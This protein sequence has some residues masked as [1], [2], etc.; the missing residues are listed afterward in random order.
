MRS[1]LGTSCPWPSCVGYKT[2]GC[3]NEAVCRIGWM[4]DN[5]GGLAACGDGKTGGS[6]SKDRPSIG[7]VELLPDAIELVVGESRHLGAIVQG[8]GDF[9]PG[10]VWESS[11]GAVVTVEDESV[12][13]SSLTTWRRS[14]AMAKPLRWA[15]TSSETSRT[16]L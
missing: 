6:S 4:Y 15:S 14:V 11:D 12:A 7:S 9:D 1:D 8:K 16:S 13:R 3:R 5:P 10:L 2:L